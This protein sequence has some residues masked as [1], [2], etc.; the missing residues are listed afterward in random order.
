MPLSSGAI[1]TTGADI[2]SPDLNKIARWVAEITLYDREAQVWYERGKRILRRYKDERSP[3]GGDDSR[4]RYNVLWSNTQTLQ[5][6]LYARNPKP[7]IQRRFK[8]ADPIG[9]VTSDVLERS[10]TYF[11]DTDGFGSGMRNCV[12]DFLLPGR[13]TT[14]LRYVPHMKPAFEVT[15]DVTDGDSAQE[16]DSPQEEIPEVIE[17]EEVCVDYV[18][19]EDFGHNICRTWEEVYCIWRKVYLS[20]DE[21]IKRFGEEKGNLPALDYTPKALNDTKLDNGIGKATIYE[22]WDKTR[23]VAVWFHKDVPEALDLRKDPLRLQDFWP[24]PR[25]IFA[26]LTN[27]SLIPTPFYVEYQD[28]A[29]ELD[30]LTARIGSLTKSIKVAGAYDASVQAL[31]RILSEGVDN[32]MIP[33]E[34]WAMF[35]EKGGIQGAM[36]FLPLKEIADG[37]LQLYSAREQVKKDLHEISG[38]PDIVRGDSNPNETLGAQQIKTSFATNRISDQQREIQRFARENIRIMVNIICE[39]FQIETIKKISGVRLFTQQE[40]AE[41]KQYQQ[42]MAQQP[43]PQPGAPPQPMLTQPPQALTGLS[44]DQIETMMT[45]PTWEEVEGLIRNQAL[46]CFRVDIETD[47]TIRADQEQDK[48]ARVEFLKAAGGFL[49]QANE[50]GAAQPEM[51]PLLGQMLMFGIRGFPVGKELEGAF[52]TALQ[53]LE[54]QAANPQ[55]KQD[56]EM[57]KVQSEAQASQARLQAETQ[58]QQTKM[59]GEMQLAQQKAQIDAQVEQ[60]KAQSQA[61]VQQHLNELENAREHQRMQGEMQLA[62]FKI[63]SE[64][65]LAIEKAH[66]AAAAS[67]EVARIGAKASDGAEAEQREASQE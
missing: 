32:T 31:G 43:P 59:Q 8:D 65:R 58:L 16:S 54:K 10:A 40:K 57:A 60:A 55:P 22:L 25:P 2:Q 6:A 42:I 24:S 5:P 53:K 9:R 7:D 52:S 12:L 27:D 66:I 20:R 4:T 17:Y 18:H 38:I 37:L 26:N 3:I 50:V 30:N 13:G 51:V 14:W 28:Q 11:C 67:I 15:D 33:V 47:S 56:P 62:Q 19:P 41:I 64:G 45:D 36:S 29:R 35:A 44:Q 48:A 23:E 63:E 1:D 61:A 21:L 46:R 34:S 49:Q 39:H